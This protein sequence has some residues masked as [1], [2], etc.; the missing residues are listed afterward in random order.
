[1]PKFKQPKFKK[2]DQQRVLRFV[3]LGGAGMVTRNM[4]AYE[5]GE[6]I[7][8]IDCGIGFPDSEMLG[9]D[10]TI[11]DISYLE[12]EGRASR[13]RG[14]VISHAHYDHF[15]ALPHI[16][17]RLPV[18]VYGSRLT[19]EFVKASLADKG[20]PEQHNLI[21]IIPEKGSFS[22]G[23]FKITPF[24]VCHSVP[25]A[26]GFFIET[27]AGNVFH[28]PDYKFDWTPLDGKLFEVGKVAQLAGGGRPLVL[29]SDCLGANDK[30]YTLSERAI[31]ASL[32][33]EIEGA[34]EQLFVVTISSNISRIAQSVTAARACGRK[35]CFLGRSMEKSGAIAEK[36]GYLTF[37]RGEIVPPRQAKKFDQSQLVYIAAGCYGQHGS[38]IERLSR[39]EHSLVDLKK[40]AKV[41]FSGDPS[42]PGARN[43]V[44][45][46]I[47]RLITQGAQVSYYEIQENMHVS[48]HGT[49]GDIQMLMG[50]VK[51]KFLIPIGGAPKHMR[52]YSVLA[53]EMGHPVDNILELQEGQLLDFSG[54]KVRRGKFSFRDVLV[55]GL[56]VGDVGEVVL[57]DRRILADDG[58]VVLIVPIATKT[59]RISGS[60][61]IATRGFVYVKESQELLSKLE[62]VVRKAVEAPPSKRQDWKK[63][64]RQIERQA[65]QFITRE[66]GRAPL[67]LPVI[68][69]T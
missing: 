5:C 63:L 21:E 45:V 62:R 38:A 37:S 43:S 20:S 47:D 12:K 8:I 29:V 2:A 40:G 10:V 51:P 19:L 32:A 14:I 17:P 25:D 57:K 9:V 65:S 15:G 13:V 69:K 58:V 64:R 35:V 60:V 22:L 16:L 24:R 28:V 52:S 23:C 68:I 41:I 11:P 50:L 30:G 44:D 61:E 31:G 54:E 1:M 6:D 34:Q 18:P 46:V 53:Q 66:T 33:K 49:A 4:F 56:R 26:L 36:L 7:V 48:G 55:D 42:P 27:P 67:I 59:G 39:E 3:P